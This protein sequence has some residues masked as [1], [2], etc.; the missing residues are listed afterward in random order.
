M[1]SYMNISVRVL[2][3]QAQAQ[4]KALQAQVA[5]LEGQLATANATSSAPNAIGNARSRKTL[6]AWGNQIQWTGRQLQ[7]NWTLPIVLAGAA[8]TKFALDNEKAFTRVKKV[9]GDAADAAAYFQK[10]QEQIPEGMTAAEAA[11]ASFANELDALGEAFEALSSRYGINQKQVLETAGAWA[12]A[13]SSGIAL[14]RSTQLSIKAAILGDMELGKATESLIAIQAQYSLSTKQLGLTL[15]ELNAIENQ[16]GISLQGLIDGFARTAGVARESGI[17]VR[18]LGAML[19]ALVPATGSAANAGNALKTIISRIMSPT[20]DAADVMR[21]FGVDTSTSMW[22]SST[23]ME[24][25]MVLA[26]HMGEDLKK[27]AKGGYVLSDSQKQVVASVLGSRYQMNRFLVLMR[28]LGPEHSYYEKALDATSDRTKVFAQATKELNAVLNSSPK[29]LEIMWATLQNGMADAIQPMIPYIIYLAQQIAELVTW[30]S[31]LD[32]AVQKLALVM[33]VA[34]AAVGPLVKYMGSLMTLIGTMIMPIRFLAAQWIALTT[35]HKLVDGAVVTSRLTLI[36]LMG[37]MLKMPFVFM[38]SGFMKLFAL[39][40]VF[41]FFVIAAGRGLVVFVAMQKAMWV[42]IQSIWVVAWA[43]LRMLSTLGAL[44]QV[45]I[46]GRMSAAIRVISTGLWRSVLMLFAGGM[47]SLKVLLGTG[48]AKIGAF[49]ARFGKFLVSPWGIAILAILGLFALFHDQ[50][51]QIWNNIVEYFSDSSNLMTSQ[52]IKAWNMLPQGVTNALVAV[53]KVVQTIAL[54]IYEWFSYINPFAHHSPSLV[55]NVTLGMKVVSDQFGKASSAIKGHISG[56]Y[57]DIKAFGNAIKSLLNGAASFEEAQN[58]KKIKKFAPGALEEYDQLSSRLKQLKG[59]LASLEGRVNSQQRVVDAWTKKVEQAN[60]AIDRQQEK[61]DRLTVIQNKWQEKLDKANE[62]LDKFAN[63]PIRGMGAMSDKIFENEMAQKRLRLEMMKLEDANGPL[64]DIK[65]R[66]EAINGMQELLRGEKASLRSAGAGSDILSQ[67]DAEIAALEEQKK[68]Q[69]DAASSMQQMSDALDQL[70]RQGEQLDLENSL[71]FDP[72]TR[73]I[74]QAA[75]A[76]KELPFD[77]IMAGVQ[78]AQADIAKYQEKLDDATKAVEAQQSVVDQATAARDRMQASLDREE[79]TLS[80][81]KDQYDKVAEAISAVEQ[82]MNDAASAA[83]AM[84]AAQEAKKKKKKGEGYVSPAVQNFRDA[85][86]GNFADVGGAGIPVRTNWKDQSDQIKKFT[87]RMAKQAAG[88]FSDLNPFDAIK[89]KWG[90]FKVWFA[91]VWDK[92][93]AGVKDMLGSAFEGVGGSDKLTKLSDKFRIGW[94]ATKDWFNEKIADPFRRLWATFSG[95]IEEFRKNAIQGWRDL[96]AN[97]APQVDKFKQVFRDAAPALKGIAN[98]MK[99]VAGLIV[100]AVGEIASVFVNVLAK[101]I[102]PILTT[103]GNVIENAIQIFQGTFKIITGFLKLFTSDWKQGLK[104]I[105]G[106][107]WDILS[108]LGGVIGNIFKGAFEIALGL[109]IGVVKGIWSFFKWLWDELVGHSIVPDMVEGII[110]CFKLL[111]VVPKWIWDHVLKPIFDFVVNIWQDKIKPELSQWRDRFENV[112]NALTAISGWFWTNVVK[113]V[114]DKIV[115]IWR[116]KIKPE[117][118]EWRARFEAAWSVL[119]GIANWFWAN[120]VKPVFDKVFDI[121]HDKIKPELE[122]WRSRFESA[123]SALTNLGNWFKNNVTDPIFNKLTGV[124]SDLKSWFDKNSDMLTKPA[125]T[126]ANGVITAINGLISGLNKVADVVPGLKWNIDLIPT[127]QL[128]AG[129][130]IP[131]RFVGSG[132]KTNGARAIVG[133]GKANHPEYV[134]P[135]DPTHRRRAQTLLG[136]A[137]KSI[138][139]SQIGTGV[140]GPGGETGDA[141]RVLKNNPTAMSGIP[142]YDIGGVIG[143]IANHIGDAAS[144]SADWVKNQGKNMIS[145]IMNVPL[146]YARE[147]INKNDW[148]AVRDLGNA[149]VNEVASW[150]G[151]ADKAVQGKAEEA[152]DKAMGGP[153]IRAALAWAKTQDGASYRM[154][155]VGPD[156]YDC[157]GFMAAITNHIRGNPIHNRLGA[158]SSFP[159]AGFKPGVGNAK[160][161]TIGSTANYAGSGV[162]HMAGTLGGINVESRGGDGVVIGSAARGYSD[163]GFNEIAHLKMKYGGIIRARTGGTVFRGGEAG[164]DE[165]VLPLPS[166]WSARDGLGEKHY[167]FYGDLSFP[168]IKSGEDAETFIK[169]L[170]ILAKD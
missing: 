27:T 47:A 140:T 52:I 67:Y 62:K 7:Y 29:R 59:D 138:G 114:F 14:A 77:V 76:M 168:N 92:A 155:T 28:E 118:S 109:V 22:Q 82:A 5:R 131:K 120:V 157:S 102:K 10:H 71:Q 148:F 104:D 122:E 72:L 124:W 115:D 23:A 119:A 84:E 16:T 51:A 126:M 160:G 97:I 100:I 18:H 154:G 15:A 162:G 19:A 37:T 156:M 164:Q 9:Y 73:Q 107:V 161:F 43:K 170:E 130:E 68:V 20:K 88:A 78:G 123:W 32:P 38:A 4:I 95:P 64:D 61:L 75:Y 147:K 74:E 17:D 12:A 169:N 13:G 70:Q 81:I 146:D 143:D 21:E 69:T 144:G 3:A 125:K 85:A 60:A 46:W 1:N 111:I 11:S 87:D 165:A 57:A 36:G 110:K 80:R 8:A 53:A 152:V 25:L 55:E 93:V 167:H 141:L 145:G 44:A 103:I 42:G 45:S 163:P 94:Q 136:M 24:R 56:A 135:T 106:G 142:Q 65:S 6:G 128:A 35:V 86:G 49:M 117:L 48:F 26:G 159:W 63:A 54:Q 40:K 139:V 166:N 34:L 30:F 149:Y 50:I 127:F 132:F 150:V 116:D 83:A 151:A 31:N 58:R 33:L 134:I 101:V 113:P 39:F 133:E 129:G 90:Q 153:R 66:M 105:I 2:S 91:G 98:V 99:I 158:T 121:W 89:Q 108:G 96:V 112:W 79:A 41:P 137:A